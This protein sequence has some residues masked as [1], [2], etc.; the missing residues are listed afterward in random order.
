MFMSFEV[1]C[2]DFH[3]YE[4]LILFFSSVLSGTEHR[5]I[6]DSEICPYRCHSESVTPGH[7][8]VSRR[9][10]SW[11]D[12]FPGCNA[13]WAPGAVALI[14]ETWCGFYVFT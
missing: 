3:E 4:T 6:S 13:E 11:S 7:G 9:S 2:L 12:C 1:T 5:K 10:Q 8:T 14:R